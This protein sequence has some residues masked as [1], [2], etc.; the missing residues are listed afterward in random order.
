MIQF[1]S[2]KSRC[3][4][5]RINVTSTIVTTR[6]LRIFN[7]NLIPLQVLAFAARAICIVL[8]SWLGDVHC[9]RTFFFFFERQH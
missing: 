5:D 7:E 2:L 8:Y 6:S 1:G 4:V 3:D 9:D